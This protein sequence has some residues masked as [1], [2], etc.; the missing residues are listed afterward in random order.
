[1]NQMCNFLEQKYHGKLWFWYKLQWRVLGLISWKGVRLGLNQW[2]SKY[3]LNNN[4]YQSICFSLSIQK[5]LLDLFKNISL[6]KDQNTIER[7]I[8]VYGI[9]VLNIFP[10]GVSVIL[11]LMCGFAV[12][13]SPAF[14][15]FS[16]FWL[17]V[18]CK[19]CFMVL[20]HCSFE[21]SSL[22]KIIKFFRFLKENDYTISDA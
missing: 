13:P 11:I 2:V 7:D 10:R 6:V 18:L 16:S 22:T 14:C 4:C 12:S 20:W 5:L 19:R 15:G 17:T 1:M 8:G 9:V 3:K 21:L